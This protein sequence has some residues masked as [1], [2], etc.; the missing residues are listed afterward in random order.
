MKM[1]HFDFYKINLIFSVLLNN[2][3]NGKQ[4]SETELLTQASAGYG[5]HKHNRT[6]PTHEIVGRLL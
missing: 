3:P 2:E 6:P 4:Q 1:M 5:R